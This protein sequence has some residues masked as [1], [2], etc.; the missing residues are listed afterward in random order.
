MNRR[1]LVRP[2]LAAS[3][4]LALALSGTALA[5]TKTTLGPNLVPNPGFEQSQNDAL[6]DNGIPVPPVGWTFEG[7]TIVF[8]YK[9]DGGHTGRHRV[10]ISGSLAPGRQ[11]CDA[12][13]GA[14][15]CVPNPAASGTSQVNDAALPYSSIRPFWVS[16]APIPVAT[17]KTY[18]FGMY[19]LRPS[20]DPSV[21]VNGEGPV[22][23]VRWVNASG[24]TVSVVNGPQAL[25]TAKRELGYRFSTLDLV[26]PAGAVGAKLLLG[27][28]DYT[29]TSA[30]VAFDDISFAQVTRR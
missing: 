15:T 28:S 14:Y 29:V 8:D 27:H 5:G 18:R 13:T 6:V 22:S 11:I 9:G 12:S 3:A 17:G 7:A 25:K 2:A 23:K 24:S 10:A 26:A 4:C 21:G 16:A 1:Q 20:F 30:Q 19:S